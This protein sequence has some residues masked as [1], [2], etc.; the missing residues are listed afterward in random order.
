VRSKRR[1]K[2]V[3]RTAEVEPRG[4]EE[5]KNKEDDAKIEIRE[6]L[7]RG[8]WR[9]EGNSI[10]SEGKAARCREPGSEAEGR[11]RDLLSKGAS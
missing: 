5:G 4:G 7:E 3:R 1:E 6:V 8:K 10:L 9:A 2:G 11:K